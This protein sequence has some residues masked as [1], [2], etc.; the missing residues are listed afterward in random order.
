MR[1]DGCKDLKWSEAEPTE[2]GGEDLGCLGAESGVLPLPP[3]A[4]PVPYKQP[5][6]DELSFGFS[7]SPPGSL[8]ISS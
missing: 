4:C 1:D 6:L 5:H 2:A 8:I 7:A 3:G